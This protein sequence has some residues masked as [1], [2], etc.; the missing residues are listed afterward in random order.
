MVPGAL[1]FAVVLVLGALVGGGELISRYRDAP[2]KALR[3][4]PALFYLGVNAAAAVSA[5]ALVRVFGWTFGVSGNPDALRWV[6]VLVAG[7]SAMALFRSSL[8]VVRAGTQDIGVGPSGFLQVVLAA[9]DAAVDRLRGTDRSVVVVKIM[10][11][12]SFEKAQSALP[13]Y[14]IAL[15]QN[16]SAQDLKDLGNGV[17]SIAADSMDAGAKSLCLGLLLMNYVGDEVLKAAVD[18]LGTQIQGTPT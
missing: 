11:P 7:F 5:L 8:F 9:A 6:Q 12:V 18:A 10:K 2:T 16:I 14:C 1:D 17:K 4:T 13:T 15:M 3:S